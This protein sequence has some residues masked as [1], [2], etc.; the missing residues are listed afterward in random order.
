MISLVLFE[1][2]LEVHC[3][4]VFLEPATWCLYKIVYTNN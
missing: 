2:C 1:S 4:G 3:L